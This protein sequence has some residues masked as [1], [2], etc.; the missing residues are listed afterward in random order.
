MRRILLFKKTIFSKFLFVCTSV[1]FYH[2]LAVFLEVPIFSIITDC[3]VWFELVAS[4]NLV[5]EGRHQSDIN[6]KANLIIS[7]PLS[8]LVK[9]CLVIMMEETLLMFVFRISISFSDTVGAR[10]LNC[11]SSCLIKKNI[12]LTMNNSFHSNKP[13]KFYV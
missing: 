2:L 3:G 11:L 12:S 9:G 1:S 10:D 6:I 8:D 5:S 7:R 13:G 4:L